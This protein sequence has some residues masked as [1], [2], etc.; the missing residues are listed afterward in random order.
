MRSIAWLALAGLAVTPPAAAAQGSCDDIGRFFSKPPKIGEWADMRMD[1][2]KDQG[3]KPMAMRVGFVGEEKRQGKQMYRM[4][5]IMS[6]KDGQQQIMQTLTPW[7]AEALGREF[8]TEIVMKMGDQQAMIMPV[9]ADKAQK[10]DI[11]T[12][13]AKINF[14]GEETI[15]VPAGSFKARHYKGPDGE[16]WVSP[17]VPGWRM[18]KMVTKDGDELVLTGT[19]TGLEN[20]ITEKPVDM[21]EM[22]R[23]PEA[24]K[25]MMEGNK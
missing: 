23:N 25:R 18:V 13:C 15:S 12:E 20:Q 8:D 22:M 1:M 14:V 9:K 4:Q 7:G 24:V 17:D 10:W 5:M 11:R 6:G 19:G 2:K 16:S 3:K 21:K